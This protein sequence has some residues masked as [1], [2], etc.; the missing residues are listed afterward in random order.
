MDLLK[1]IE[2]FE[3]DLKAQK[4]VE[5]D[6]FNSDDLNDIGSVEREIVNECVSGS[7]HSESESSVDEQHHNT[8]DNSNQD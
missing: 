4:A 1:K 2:K 7:S 8:D 3:E 6:E 5:D